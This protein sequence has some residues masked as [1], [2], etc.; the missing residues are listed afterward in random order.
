MV[1]RADLLPQTGDSSTQR[2]FT[3]KVASGGNQDA[4]V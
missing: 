3:L 4:E 1:M 2:R